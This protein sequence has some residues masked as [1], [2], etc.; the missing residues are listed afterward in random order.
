[1][2][3]FLI[4]AS[5]FLGKS[6]LHKCPNSVEILGSYFQ[7]DQDSTIALDVREKNKMESILT[8]LKYDVIIHC[9]SLRIDV[10]ERDPKL[11][12]SINVE[13]TK[14]LVEICKKNNLYLIYISSDAIFDG[15]A[16]FNKEQ[17]TPN[18]LGVFGKTKV[19]SESIIRENLESYCILRTSNLFGWDKKQQNFA[20][21]IIHER[22]QNKTVKVISDQIISPSYCLNVADIIV[23]AATKKVKGIYHVAGK[24]SVTRYDFA[25]KIAT[26]FNLDEKL[27][28][29]T[30]ISELNLD[31]KRGK[32]CS[33]D[34]T[35]LQT[36][37]KTSVLSIDEALSDMYSLKESFSFKN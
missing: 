30:S 22:S 3:V 9:G 23:E 34:T 14:N 12:Y 20:Q 28:I 16:K 2:R 4:G 13:G 35:K 26:S 8:N 5:G 11:A 32:N 27:L 6:I 21:W 25:Q 7:N 33:L 19:E 29:P 24:E 37:F 36:T 1:M 17:T 18:P 15:T 10:C 31:M